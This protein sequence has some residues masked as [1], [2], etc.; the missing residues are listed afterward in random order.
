MRYRLETERVDLFDTN[1]LIVMNVRLNVRVAF[2]DLRDSFIRT[3][4]MHE[5][6]RSKVIIEPSGEAYY[7]DNDEPHNSIT[8]TGSSLEEL[9]YVNERRRFRIEEGE[10]IRAFVSPDGLIFMMHHLG[11]DGKSL[12]YFIETFMKCLEGDEAEY[13]PFRNLPFEDIP[14]ESGLSFGYKFLTRYWNRK[15]AKLKRTYT[16]RDMDEEYSGFWTG[17]K[18]DVSVRRYDKEELDTLLKRSREIGVS[19]TSYLITGFIEGSDK[20]LALGIAADG[21]TDGNRS[22]GN[23]VTGIAIKVRYDNRQS[24]EDNARRVDRLMKDKLSD[25]KHRYFSLE[26]MRH[27]EPTLKDALNLVR[28]GFVDGS[29]VTMVAGFLGYGKKIRDM[30]FTNLTRADIGLQYGDYKIEEIIFV[31]PVVSYAKDVIGIITTGNIMNVTRH[32]YGK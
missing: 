10:F 24:F 19:L 4:D 21:R 31:P 14:D 5:V 17:R 6:L 16:Y 27:L 11:G 8:E 1:I 23:Q 18:T 13:V 28:A 9:I 15:W 25:P 20:K 22:M 26:F 29:F 32:V 7:V 2:D 12:L 3:C 30:S